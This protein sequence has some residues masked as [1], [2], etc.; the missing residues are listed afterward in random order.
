MT[1]VSILRLQALVQFASSS[2]LTFDN[3]PTGQWSMIEINVGIICACMPS[4][5]VLLLHI[6]PKRS[7]KQSSS[8]YS[9]SNSDGTIRNIQ[10]KVENGKAGNDGIK[11][12]QSYTVKYGG[13]NGQSDDDGAALVPLDD[14]E[15]GRTK[16]GSK[17]KEE[18]MS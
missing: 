12:T 10:R 3:T 16:S 15:A 17:F 7:S 9:R 8:G 14:L 1:I 18:D 4:M 2:N 5:R 11:F 6:F 13:H